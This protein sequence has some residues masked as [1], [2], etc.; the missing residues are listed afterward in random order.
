MAAGASRRMGEP[1]QLLSFQGTPLIS[2]VLRRLAATQPDRLIVVLGAHAE[3]IRQHCQNPSV[4]IFLNPNWEEGLSASIRTAVEK[5]AH[6]PEKPSHILIALVDQPYL[7]TE[8]YQ[9]LIQASKQFPDQIIAAR[10]EGRLGAP[11][12]FPQAY[13]SKLLTLKE[14]RG[15]GQWVRSL[16]EQVVPIDL[17]LAA[18]DWDRPEDLSK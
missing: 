1:K 3:R 11:M 16:N 7:E 6:S 18:V 4:E 5:L 8:H 2:T 14:D 17:P 9:S 12:L 13:F 15:A 10:F